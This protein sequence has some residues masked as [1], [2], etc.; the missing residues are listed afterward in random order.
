MGYDA[1]TYSSDEN[2]FDIERWRKNFKDWCLKPAM[3]MHF[4]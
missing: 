3:K 1:N 4:M 2:F